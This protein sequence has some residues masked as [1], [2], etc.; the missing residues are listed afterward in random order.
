MQVPENTVDLRGMQG[1]EALDKIEDAMQVRASESAGRTALQ[2]WAC[3]GRLGFASY[4][5]QWCSCEAWRRSAQSQPP[6][7]FRALDWPIPCSPSSGHRG[8]CFCTWV[9]A[10]SSAPKGGWPGHTAGS[11]AAAVSASGTQP[12]PTLTPVFAFQWQDTLQR[13][14]PKLSDWD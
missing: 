14:P 4:M 2:A 1:D 3:P 7:R 6:R 10:F 11:S 8:R 5:L 12:H 9:H 13:P